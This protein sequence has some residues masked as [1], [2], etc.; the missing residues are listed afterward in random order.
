MVSV[1]KTVRPPIDDPVR[2][3]LRGSADGDVVRRSWRTVKTAS[4]SDR[5]VG[6]Y[7]WTLYRMD[8]LMEVSL[9]VVTNPVDRPCCGKTGSVASRLWTVEL[10]L[11]PG[12]SRTMTR[13]PAFRISRH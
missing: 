1:Y 11:T 6:T 9:W 5:A 13:N 8:Q 2:K 3:V 4:G 7:P 10:L 12:I